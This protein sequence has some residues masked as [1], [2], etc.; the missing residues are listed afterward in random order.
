MNTTDKGPYIVLLVFAMLA[1]TG[2]FFMFDK[3]GNLQSEVKNLELALQ[4]AEQKNTASAQPS[5]PTLPAPTNPPA[6]APTSTPTQ[7]TVEIPTAIIFTA[8]SSPLLA[9]Q[10]SL[11]VTVES[12]ARAEDGTLTLSI[13]VFTSQAS[14]YSALD[15]KSFFE[16]VDLNGDNQSPVAITG[17]FSSMPPKSAITGTV[18][19]QMLP[20]KKTG[21]IQMR[22][23][24]DMKFYEFDFEKRTYRETVIG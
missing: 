3:I 4:L 6:P 8:S 7:S 14:S 24:D 19:F 9:P 18:Q 23:G 11:S 12:A 5:M 10:T 17:A 1:L 16:L 21:I 13:K 20:A 22:T 15:T 2:F